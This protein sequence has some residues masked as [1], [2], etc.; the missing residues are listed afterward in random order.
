M[1]T[2]GHGVV[3][4]HEGDERTPQTTEGKRQELC[5]D[6]LFVNNGLSTGNI[7]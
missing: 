7:I 1:A 3:G 2:D 4:N 5:A 6:S